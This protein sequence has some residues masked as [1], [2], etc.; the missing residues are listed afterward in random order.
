MIG[1]EVETPQKKSYK[2]IPDTDYDFCPKCGTFF[3][4]ARMMKEDSLKCICGFICDESKFLNRADI[5]F[6]D[7]KHEEST[8]DESKK[9]KEQDVM[10]DRV[11]SKCGNPEMTY[12]AMQTR[13]ADEGQTLFYFCPNCKYS[14]V[15]YS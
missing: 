10:T 13:S 3:N 15:E 1:T 7:I 14:E 9:K 6:I 4:T 2:L 12:K 8:E 5:T 11:C